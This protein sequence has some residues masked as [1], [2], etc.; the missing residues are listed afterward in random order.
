LFC[1]ISPFFTFS[2]LYGREV[3]EWFPF[4]SFGEEPIINALITGLIGGLLGPYFLPE[5]LMA[6]ALM[7]AIA[8]NRSRAQT[9]GAGAG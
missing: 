1:T 6:W 5:I 8:I 7:F 2:S 9:G 4:P 3:A